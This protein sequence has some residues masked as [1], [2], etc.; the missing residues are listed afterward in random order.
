MR[1]EE[2]L[3]R[4]RVRGERLELRAARV[5]RGRGAAAP[6]PRA[7]RRASCQPSPR[8]VAPWNP[9]IVVKSAL[10]ERGL[11]RELD[12]VRR[13][14][15]RDQLLRRAE[16]DALAVIDDGDAVAEALRFFH[17]VRGEQDRSAA[18]RGSRVTISHNC[19]RLCGSRP[20]VGSSRKRMSGSPTS[21]QATPRR[22]FW[23]PES[24][25]TR[26]LRFSSSDRLAQQLLGIAARCDRTSE[27]G[28]ASRRP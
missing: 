20:V 18:L 15:R 28:A 17:V 19:R 24:L 13:L 23:P 21:A 6:R 12:D 16:G 8:R 26:A 4:R 25:P 3:E 7:S 11:G 9:L 14:E 2:V 27:T 1:D 10:L 22:C 5:D